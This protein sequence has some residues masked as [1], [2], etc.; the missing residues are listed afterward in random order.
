VSPLDQLTASPGAF[1][2]IM[3]VHLFAF[4]G[5]SVTIKL[6][7][8]SDN[9][10]DAYADVTGATTSALS[11]ARQGLRIATAAVDV[12]RYLKVVTTGTFTNAQ[13]AVSVYRHRTQT[14][15]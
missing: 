2:L 15:Y 3:F 11:A 4:T 13:F 1:G 10:G 6:Q 9:A 5:T 7:S 12:E 8:S 14:D